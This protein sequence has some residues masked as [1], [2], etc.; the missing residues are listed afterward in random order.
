MKMMVFGLIVASWLWSSMP[1][2]A[3]QPEAV[4]SPASPSDRSAGPSDRW[5]TDQEVFHCTFDQENWDKNFDHWPDRWTRHQGPG[6]PVYLEMKRVDDPTVSG[7]GAFQVKLDGGA[8][9]VFSPPI[10]VR[11]VYAYVLEVM[12]KTQDLQHHQAYV[13]LSFLDMK[14]QTLGRYESEKLSGTQAWQKVRLGP[15]EVQPTEACF[16]RIGLHVEPGVQADLK[17]EAAFADVWLGR[18]PRLRMWVK[19]RTHLFSQDEKVEIF[20]EASGFTNPA[21]QIE[22]ELRDVWGRVL[23]NQRE[24]LPL[25]AAPPEVLV[26]TTEVSAGSVGSAP[27]AVRS[28]EKSSGG[29]TSDEKRSNRSPSRGKTSA[30]SPSTGTTNTSADSDKKASPDSASRRAGRS[31]PAGDAARA[32]ANPSAPPTPPKPEQVYQS[33]VVWRPTLPGPGFYRVHCR[34]VGLSARTPPCQLDLGVLGVGFQGNGGEF[35]WGLPEGDH[36]L[37]LEELAALL[38]QMGLRWIKYPVWFDLKADADKVD[39]WVVFSERLNAQGI[40]IVGM[41][42]RPPAPVAKQFAARTPLA[43]DIFAMD[44]SLWWP[45][46]EP[47]L[48]RLAPRIHWWQL[49]LDD[50]QSFVGLERLEEKIGRVKS[51]WE[52]VG[53]DL[54]V[55]FGW[56]WM[57][58]LPKARQGTAPW[59][60]L[61]FRTAPPLAPDELAEA[62]RATANSGLVR[63]ATIEPLPKGV[64]P[65]EERAADLVRQMASAKIAGADAVFLPDPFHPQTGLMHP[66]GTVDEL[67]LVWR[68]MAQALAGAQYLGSLSTP[69]RSPNHLLLRGREALLIIWNEIPTEEVLY[70][71]DEVQQ[72]DLWGRAVSVDRQGDLQCLKVSRLP[73]LVRG[74]DPAVAQWRM[75]CQIAVTRI[76]SLFGRPHP[77]SLKIHNPLDRGVSGSAKLVLP[78]G[79]TAQ[80]EQVPFRLG[81]GESIEAPFTLVLPYT[82]A[83][84]RYPIQVDVRLQVDRLYQFRVYRWLDVGLGDVYIQIAARLNSQQELEVEQ[85]LVNETEQPVAFQC[86]L[87]APGR[88]RL[89]TYVVLAGEGQEVF[90]YRFPD[91]QD[92]VGKTLWLQ[93][94]EQ[95]GQRVL[96][97][98][99]PVQPPQTPAKPAPN[100]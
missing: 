8:A 76:P 55:G 12:V 49:G 46:V 59:K 13:S 99:F 77:N 30:K 68:T 42:A 78:P 3:G 14:F 28:D 39:A 57:Y 33:K 41:L 26:P 27:K 56:D 63:W 60:F 22:W 9:A 53:K 85:R 18:L 82:A 34:L 38:S 32:P 43:A 80:P 50:D 87:F 6:Y 79:W 83:N 36:P 29:N 31:E 92:L 45:A 4:S 75:H 23:K 89:Q 15:V 51:H 40:E 96:N 44:P 5:P 88:K 91:G 20:C 65:L 17:G 74:L 90:V 69:N 10:P 67:L 58:D 71:G 70:L 35:G 66:D 84:G 81:P 72:V 93:A 21:C 19:P 94:V 16:V 2:E 37:P 97:Y 1:T 73:C 100:R 25:E 62:I 48:V 86:Q 52:K 11:A 95:G 24:T 98:R 47:L 54:Q 61:A 7:G 64:Y